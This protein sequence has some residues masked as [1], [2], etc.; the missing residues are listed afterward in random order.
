MRCWR[1]W[2]TTSRHPAR[3][4]KCWWSTQ[5]FYNIR[6]RIWVVIRRQWA[7]D[8]RRMLRRTWGSAVPAVVAARYW[9]GVMY[10]HG[11]V[12][13]KN[14]TT[15]RNQTSF[16]KLYTVVYMV[17]TVCIATTVSIP[18]D[19]MLAQ[20]MLWSCVCRSQAGMAKHM[21]MKTTIYDSPGTLVFLRQRS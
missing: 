17:I 3:P 18:R 14:V 12:M 6:T 4:A 1:A 11:H 15:S 5:P 2:A 19:A 13:T 21:V 9:L 16:S 7:M 8:A 20:C 10:D